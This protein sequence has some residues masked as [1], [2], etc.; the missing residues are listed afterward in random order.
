MRFFSHYFSGLI[1]FVAISSNVLA[2]QT[3]NTMWTQKNAEKWVKSKVWSNGRPLT[4][5]PSTN[6]VEF[7]RQ[8]EKNKAAW[9]KAFAFLN[10]KKLD[11]LAP[12]KYV[13]DGDDVY[14]MITEA[15]S[16]EFD[17]SAWE[18]HRKYIDLQHVIRG[19]EKI[20][21]APVTSATITNPYDET[22]DAAN[23]TA[24]GK[25]YVASPEIFFLFFPGDAH[26][27]NIQIESGD[28]TKVKKM[29]IKIRYI[30]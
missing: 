25:Y 16:K 24:E 28:T 27:P 29:V 22:K 26:R 2:Q 12:G 19:K 23:Y 15:P 21:V 4:I 5:H 11:T 20:G 14:A 3:T 8:Y 10:D 6:N 18:S 13:I 17:K 7:A 9:D 1:I 30:N